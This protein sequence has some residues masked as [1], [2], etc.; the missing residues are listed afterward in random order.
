MS[1]RYS[2]VG[3]WNHDVNGKLL[4]YFHPVYDLPLQGGEWTTSESPVVVGLARK[5]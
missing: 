3:R 1:K 4:T 2:D 5:E